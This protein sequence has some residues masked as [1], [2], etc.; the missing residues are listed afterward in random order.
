MAAAT[1]S[2][3]FGAF[4]H[5]EVVIIPST[6]DGRTYLVRNLPDKQAAADLIASI[7]RDLLTVVDYAIR[8]QDGGGGASGDNYVRAKRRLEDAVFSEGS[9]TSGYTSFSV[10]KG[11]RIV[12][13]LRHPDGGFA[14]RNVLNY[15]ALHELAHVY[16]TEIGHTKLFWTNFKRILLLAIK[17]GVYRPEDFARHP[18]PY[19]GIT[20][21]QSL[22]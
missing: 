20:I 15:V 19:C 11:E 10:N 8:Q 2:L 9:H 16:T 12:L 1:A 21:S 13:C 7:R 3:Y 22:V 17:V 6:V 18:K 5:N 14:Q 4:L